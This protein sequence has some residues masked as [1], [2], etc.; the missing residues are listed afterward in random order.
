MMT[1][2]QLYGFLGKADLGKYQCALVILPNKQ[3]ATQFKLDVTNAADERDF[4][5][6]FNRASMRFSVFHSKLYVRVAHDRLGDS[7]RGMLFTAVYGLSCLERF[8]NYED[9]AA[10][11]KAHM[12]EPA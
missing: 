6:R 5:I 4:P 7:V 8:D 12:R 2:D 3:A 11:I 1:R 10:K 9:Q